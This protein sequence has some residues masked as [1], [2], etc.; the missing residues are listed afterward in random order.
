VRVGLLDC[1]IGS[2]C[3]LSSPLRLG[4]RP[5]HLP[6]QKSFRGGDCKESTS[7]L[8]KR[9]FLAISQ[10]AE[11]ELSCNFLPRLRRGEVPRRRPR[12]RGLPQKARQLNAQSL[13]RISPIPTN[14]IINSP[15]PT[16]PPKSTT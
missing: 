14:T 13:R 8:L 16:G 7:S 2:P 10:L 15:P 12:R 11:E 5:R 4:L 1:W 6:V 9:S 3:R